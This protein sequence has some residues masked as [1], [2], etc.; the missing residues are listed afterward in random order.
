MFHSD[1]CWEGTFTRLLSETPEETAPI[2]NLEP[3]SVFRLSVNPQL[4]C[5]LPM[6]VARHE[7]TFAG[8]YRAA[9]SNLP[10]EF[11]PCHPTALQGDQPMF[12]SGLQYQRPLQCQC[13]PSAKFPRGKRNFSLCRHCCQ[14]FVVSYSCWRHQS[15]GDQ[16]RAGISLPWKGS[17]AAL[18]QSCTL[19]DWSNELLQSITFHC[20][21][22]PQGATGCFIGI[23]HK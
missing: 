9:E 22:P 3:K 15:R 20:A 5:S 1:I 18:G 14:P 4:S 8:S 17:G 2:Y 19:G 6:G 11:F 12:C 13:S 16:T 7:N 23:T 10:W 21:F